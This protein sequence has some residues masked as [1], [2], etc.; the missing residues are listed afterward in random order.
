VELPFGIENTVSEAQELT[1]VLIVEDEFII[2]AS[3]QRSLQ[4]LGYQVAGVVDRADDLDERISTDPPDLILMDIEINGETDGI[5]AARRIREL[6][7]IPVVYISGLREE[8]LLARIPETQPF[9][10]LAK[11][12]TEHE[13]SMALSIAE[14]KARAERR[15]RDQEI[16]I[17]RLLEHMDQGFCLLDE[18]GRIRYANRKILETLHLD[19]DQLRSI[20][21]SHFVTGSKKFFS[22]FDEDKAPRHVPEGFHIDP[23][24]TLIRHDGQE[25]PCYVIPQ[26]FSDPDTGILQGCFL[27][28]VDIR[29]FEAKTP[30]DVI[31]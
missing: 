5:T 30:A 23:F 14:Y 13:L 4:K 26:F 22:L 15:M 27:S 24:T 10:F 16:H 12:F 31:E 11:P 21:P 28:I 18:T 6:K 17:Q 8:E 19:L 25:I 1:R 7:D 2:A 20:H 3:L 9:G 29:H